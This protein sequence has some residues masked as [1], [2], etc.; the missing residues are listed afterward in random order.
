MLALL[1]ILTILIMYLERLFR[2]ALKSRIAAGNDG[3][4]GCFCR[5]WSRCSG[6]RWSAART[7]FLLSEPDRSKCK[8][9]T[10]TLARLHELLQSLEGAL[11]TT[12]TSPF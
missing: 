3:Q 7:C 9:P 2:V 10:L 8:W 6:E 4:M 12:V 5:S 1:T 11:S